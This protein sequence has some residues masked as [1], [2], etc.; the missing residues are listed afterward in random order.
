MTLDTPEDEVLKDIARRYRHFGILQ[1]VMLDAVRHLFQGRRAAFLEKPECRE[2]AEVTL[3]VC[4][5]KKKVLASPIQ[6]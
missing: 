3:W 1:N 2:L 4:F 6:R 5:S